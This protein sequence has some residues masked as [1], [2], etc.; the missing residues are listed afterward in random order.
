MPEEFGS[1]TVTIDGD[2]ITKKNE[3]LSF[4]ASTDADPEINRIRGFCLKK[5]LL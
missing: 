4:F 2:N 1:E 3:L 5:D